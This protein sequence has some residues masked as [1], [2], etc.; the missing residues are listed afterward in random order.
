MIN[1]KKN[2]TKML[3]LSVVETYKFVKINNVYYITF[4]FYDFPSEI[5]PFCLLH[6]VFSGGNVMCSQM[7]NPL[8]KSSVLT[9]I[10]NRIAAL[11]AKRHSDFSK[12][13][14]RDSSL[15]MEI[16]KLEDFTYSLISGNS[17]GFLMATY[18]T[19]FSK[20]L[21]K[22]KILS[23]NIQ[24][25]AES[26]GFI[27]YQLDLN[28]VDGFL[29]SFPITTY[30]KFPGMVYESK[31]LSALNFLSVGNPCDY[32]G[33]LYGENVLSKSLCILD[34]FKLENYNSVIF[35]KSGAGKSFLAKTTIVRMISKGIK[36]IVIDPEGEYVNL[37]KS[38]NGK[39]V[40]FANKNKDTNNYTINPL[41]LSKDES[42]EDKI[43]FIE[44]F[45]KK[46]SPRFDKN[47]LDK[48]LLK[49][50]R[51]V[52]SPTFLDL[53][54][55]L[56]EFK[57]IMA[58]EIFPIA[59]GSLSHLYSKKT[60]V[61][62]NK[63]DNLIVFDISDLVDDNIPLMMYVILNYLWKLKDFSVK[64]QIF[65][66]EAHRLFDNF[67]LLNNLKSLTKRARK[68]NM[69]FCYITQDIGDVIDTDKGRSILANTSLK[70][71]LKQDKVNFDKLSHA[72]S[73]SSE[74]LGILTNLPIGSSLMLYND[75]HARIRHF[76]FEFEKTFFI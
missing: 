27:L 71:L 4:A 50:F 30:S 6:F 22:L 49:L 53:Y 12:G 10:K 70:I 60:N 23:K 47:V 2:I 65:I 51:E 21:N 33:I 42:I 74:E 16:A 9:A 55:I 68:Y 52:S 66:D 19:L 13:K 28:H 1:I 76:A 45:L 58:D 24:M 39:L 59:K 37:C 36:V 3:P 75:I 7:I 72:L 57:N 29:Y 14:L 18:I 20:G 26:K 46:Y 56:K 17:K 40:K 43:S 67:E 35:A 38:L 54:N 25:L 48:A 32:E 62:I 73:L 11:S 5:M 34:I 44:G 8:E 31:S 64:R 61:D 41:D 15:D 63:E 69:G